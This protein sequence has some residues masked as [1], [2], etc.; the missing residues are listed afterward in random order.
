MTSGGT[1]L[2]LRLTLLAEQGWPQRLSI[3]RCDTSCMLTIL[4]LNLSVLGLSLLP[5]FPQ[6]HDSIFLLDDR[7]GKL[8]LTSCLEGRFA[9][10]VNLRMPTSEAM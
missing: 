8:A 1:G 4:A 7:S 6:R 2:E 3:N 9:Q 5:G 10:G